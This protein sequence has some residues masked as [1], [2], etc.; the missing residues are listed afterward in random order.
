MDVISRALGLL[1]ATAYYFLVGPDNSTNRAEIALLFLIVSQLTERAGG[2]GGGISFAL[3]F[4]LLLFPG[5][6]LD[7]G[8][9]LT[10]AALAGICIGRF[11]TRLV[12]SKWREFFRICFYASLFTSVVSAYWFGYISLSGFVLNIVFAPLFSFVS[13]QLG[14]PAYLFSQF[15]F[16]GNEIP[17]EI[18]LWILDVLNN[19]VLKAASL[20]FSAFPIGEHSFGIVAL[21][22]LTIVFLILRRQIGNYARCFNLTNVQ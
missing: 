1:V 12:K 16:S 7:P 20:S 22:G 9:Q 18:C 21:I 13:C 11:S 19:L 10:F 4:M 2:L 5:C 3:V 14:I 8:V 17:L 6:I 15:E